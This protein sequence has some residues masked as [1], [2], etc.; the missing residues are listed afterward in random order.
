MTAPTYAIVDWGTSSFR[1]WSIDSTGN[2]LSTDQNSSGMS[3]LGPDEFTSVL[4]KS[5]ENLSVSQSVPVV[6]C[7]MAGAAQGWL[8]APYVDIPTELNEIHL[9]AV[10][11]TNTARDVW[12]IPGLAQKKMDAPDV[13]RGE[14]TLLFGAQLLGA[15]DGVF[16]MPGT[17][18]KWAFVLG[19]RVESFQTSMTGEVFAL[20][21]KTSTLASYITDD[22]GDITTDPAFAIAV[23]EALNNPHQILNFLFSLRSA[24]LLSEAARGPG[25]A[26]R[27][28]GLL[29]G[30]EIA[31][32]L[33]TNS[34]KVSLIASGE[35]SKAYEAALKISGMSVTVLDAD[36]LIRAGLT[37]YAQLITGHRQD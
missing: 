5:M 31:G 8:E 28:S 14:E 4:E 11:P 19:G 29:I 2:I 23:H 26:A 21:S 35:I 10:K 37:H 16:C 18:S 27:L 34:T 24:P 15:G 7:G 12:I 25:L 36:E 20:L 3:T 30:L 6:I 9:S 32:M 1:S 17:H 13:M 22:V 33:S